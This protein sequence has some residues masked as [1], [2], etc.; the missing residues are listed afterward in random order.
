MKFAAAFTKLLGHEG[1]YSN[2]PADPGGETNWGVTRRVA[3][4]NGFHGDMRAFTQDDAMAIYDRLYWMK[5]SADDLPAAVRF[6]VFDAAV[7]SGVGQAT[8]WLQR[9]LGVSDDGVIG[10]QTLEAAKAADELDF[11]K[12]LEQNKIDLARMDLDNTKSAREMQTVTKSSTPAVLSYVITGG[13]FG[14]LGYML[15]DAYVSSEPLL[16][17]LGSLGT[18]WV[19]VVNFWFGSSNGS[20]AK[21]VLLANAPPPK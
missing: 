7:N 6:D 8:K 2:N 15:S 11:K 12:F 10:R 13:F 20:Q 17:M 1:G 3:E 18:A 16:V 14:I 19:A 4:A 5:V 21:D 9:A